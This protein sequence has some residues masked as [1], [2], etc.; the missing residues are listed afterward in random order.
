MSATELQDSVPEALTESH[1]NE[2]LNSEMSSSKQ[3]HEQAQQQSSRKRKHDSLSPDTPADV[4]K[5]SV[6]FLKLTLAAGAATAVV[7]DQAQVDAQPVDQKYYCTVCKHILS[8]SAFYPSYMQRHLSWCKSCARIKQTEQKQKKK[9]KINDAIVA[10]TC[11]VTKSCHTPTPPDHTRSMLERLR[12]G[13]SQ[14]SHLEGLSR[15]LTVGFDAKVA[16]PL[17]A[18]WKWQTALK[19]AIE[20]CDKDAH[21]HV[22]SGETRGVK[23]SLS[24]PGYEE[25]KWIVWAKSDLTPIKPWE[26]IPVTHAEASLFRNVPVPLRSQL[27]SDINTLHQIEKQLLQLKDICLSEPDLAMCSSLERHNQSTKVHSQ[28]QTESSSS[29]KTL[30]SELCFR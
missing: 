28:L 9:Q 19:P 12:R 21:M 10:D 11:T 17:L 6:P 5:E 29:S 1:I 24:V 26:V 18:F 14:T 27:V 13:C 2:E 23:M 8:R 16:R 20:T 7:A 15:H 3:F 4:E 30:A 25:L 22:I